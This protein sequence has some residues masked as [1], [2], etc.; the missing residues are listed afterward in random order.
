[1]RCDIMDIGKDGKK[2][3]SPPAGFIDIEREPTV[4]LEC[5]NTCR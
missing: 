4:S 3:K 2:E 1:M 5:E